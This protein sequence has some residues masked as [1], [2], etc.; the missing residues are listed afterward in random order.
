MKKKIEDELV[1]LAHRILQMRGRSD[2]ESLYAASRSLYERLALLRFIENHFSPPQPTLNKEE[3]MVY[4]EEVFQMTKGKVDDQAHVSDKLRELIPDQNPHQSDLIEPLM[5]TIKDMVAQM[6]DETSEVDEFFKENPPSDEFEELA[7]G[8]QNLPVFE[9]VK[10]KSE[11]TTEAKLKSVNDTFKSGIQI[12]L[13]DKI[14]FIKHLFDGQAEDY[15]RVL[16][17]LNTMSS[18]TEALTFIEEVIKPDY[19]FWEG[20][21]A[22]EE[23]FLSIISSRYN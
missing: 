12:G 14:A 17:Q 7:K 21:E 19:Q 6:P 13:N 11:A 9:E 8:Y 5:E 1:S 10:P 20:K 18:E 16:S 3:A 23:R 22:Y 2:I 15:N 4:L